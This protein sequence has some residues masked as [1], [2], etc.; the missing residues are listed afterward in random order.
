M[1]ADRSGAVPRSTKIIATLGPSSRD[2]ATI[3]ALAMAGANVFR[4]NAS[5]GTQADHALTYERVRRVSAALGRPLGV[6]LDLQG[7]KLRIGTFASGSI[8]L[9]AEAPFCFDLDPSP[10]D[11]RRVC[12]PHPEIFSALQPGDQLLVDDGRM[13]FIATEVGPGSIRVRALRSGT[14]SD[15]KGVNVP[16]RALSLSALSGKD[17]RDLQFGLDL[18]VDWIALSFVQRVQDVIEARELVQQRCL[19]MAKIEKPGALQ[20][21]EAIIAAADGIMVARGDLGVEMPMEQVPS[22]QKQLV[23]LARSAGKPVVIATQMLESMI[24]SPCPTRAEASDVAT[25]VYDGADAVMLSAETASGRYPVEAVRAMDGIVRHTESDSL[26]Q[27]LMQA[28]GKDGEST[29]TDVLGSAL[30]RVSELLPLSATVAYTASGATAM[31]MAQQRPRSPVLCLTPSTTVAQRLTMVWGIHPH[32][33]TAMAG[34]TRTVERATRLLHEQALAEPGKAMVLV[35][36]TPFGLP[37]ST[38]QLHVV[39][40]SF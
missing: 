11:E 32:A 33:D 22:V 38:N 35:C 9:A 19:L 15:R 36:G 28:I 17:R 8:T 10:G 1:N 2:E 34:D 39:W 26:R 12:L 40:P 25:A 5:H 18:G 30:R 6:L 4:L 14:L 21:I 13:A 24:G 37:G 16:S 31:R 3:Q 7:P 27:P 23:R 20:E 29:T